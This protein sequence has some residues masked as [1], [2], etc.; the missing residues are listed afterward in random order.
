MKNE[1]N[2]YKK[3]VNQFERGGKVLSD[4]L[5]DNDEKIGAPD[6]TKHL[7][8]HR[9][10]GTARLGQLLPVSVLQCL[11][12]DDYRVKMS[13][14][15]QFQ[16]LNKPILDKL[17]TKMHSFYVG[18]HCIYGDQF[19][20]FWKGGKDGSFRRELPYYDLSNVSSGTIRSNHTSANSGDV[21]LA[22]ALLSCVGCR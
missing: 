1:S 18:Y 3:K 17:I 20:M 7:K 11:A 13:N 14:T 21:V 4:S 2:V 9:V 5:V 15:V 6:L 19:E 12:H 22:V 16:P 10:L 8:N